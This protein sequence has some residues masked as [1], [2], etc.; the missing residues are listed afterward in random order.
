MKSVLVA[1][2][3][4]LLYR[5]N[6]SLN[7]RDTSML[8]DGAK[9]RFDL[10]TSAPGFESVAPELTALVANQVL[11][12][13]VGTTV[14]G[15]PPH[16]SVREELHSYGSSLGYNGQDTTS[17]PAVVSRNDS[18]QVPALC[19]V[20]ECDERHFPWV[21]PFPPQTPPPGFRFCSSASQVLRDHLTSY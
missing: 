2:P 21:I 9:A 12:I 13:A 17:L 5:Q 11:R 18:L 15:G 6:E 4:R 7:D 14:T 19:P 16:R 8:A 3:H 20:Q 10:V 1:M